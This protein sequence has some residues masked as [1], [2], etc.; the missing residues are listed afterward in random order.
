MT[1]V[2]AEPRTAGTPPEARKPLPEQDFPPTPREGLESA[3]RDLAAA[4]ERWARR[5]LD[6][7]VRDLDAIADAFQ[8]V[9]EE[10]VLACRQ[11]EGTTEQPEFGGEE[12]LTGP[13]AILRNVR[14]L[15]KA[16]RDI[17]RQ[18]VPQVPGPVRT[19]PNGQVS[20]QVFPSDVF[21]R[22]F[23]PRVTGEVWMEPG[24][25]ED[26]L[27]ETQALAYR[28]EPDQGAV[29]LVLGAG[30]V[31]SIGPMDALYKLFVDNHVVLYKTHPV[32][33]YLGPLIEKRWFRLVYGDVEEG[34]FLV[35]HPLVD[36]IHITGS[37]KTVEAIVFG[38]GEEGQAHK[39]DHRPQLDK[40]LSS[41]LGNVS[42]VI[43][44][45][46]PWSDGEL[47]YQAENIVSML[48]NNAGFNCNATRVVVQHEGW[49][50]RRELVERMGEFFAKAPSRDA[51]YPGARERFD[52]FLT[53]HPEA[54]LYG[55]RTDQ[56][57]PWALASGV[58]PTYEDDICFQTEAFCSFT[59]ET[60]LPA[61]DT[62]EFLRKAVDFC[63][64]TLWGTLNVTVIVHPETLT[65]P[66]LG[67]RVEQALAD[68]RYGTVSVNHWAAVG[69]A[70]ASTSWG[71]YPG[72]D[73]Y[74]IQSG[75]GVVHNTLMFSRIQKSVVRSPFRAWPKPPWFVTHRTSRELSHQLAQF[76]ADR[77][78]ARLPAI[79]WFALRG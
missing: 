48:T 59:S 32:N 4:K 8:S 57:L 34:A 31:S 40:P 23:F 54:R 47:T 55:E 9:D 39:R 13:Y 77:S 66:E 70:L 25:T 33:E 30:N 42:P 22:V 56:R 51:W 64:E 74:D 45:P 19:L 68:L 71:A 24:V 35:H 75:T 41:E 65:D 27:D 11:A 14:L 67:P 7:R 20:A 6:D 61:K 1:V 46:G 36:E 18:G 53:E 17:Q 52:R 50:R 12:W 78:L 44:V 16:L 43:V 79:T 38:P 3:V 28:G 62:A 69:Y 37:D 72:H 49:D 58:D 60:A 21:D 15:R 26:H 2:E 73:I 29:A 5:T 63:N 10:W 76:E